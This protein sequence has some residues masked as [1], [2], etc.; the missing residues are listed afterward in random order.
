MI[1]LHCSRCLAL[2][3]SVCFAPSMVKRWKE[4][5]GKAPICCINCVR[6]KRE[7]RKSKAVGLAAAALSWF[8][9][10]R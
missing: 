5:G 8:T 3:L 1:E 10:G 6:T 2:K 9:G 7:A 4:S